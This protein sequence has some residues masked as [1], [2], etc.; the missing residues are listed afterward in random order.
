M[1]WGLASAFQGL[2]YATVPRRAGAESV[3]WLEHIG[4]LDP[5]AA[6]KLLEQPD[7]ETPDMILRNT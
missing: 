7:P 2:G 4:E 6:R 5:G 1:L 3:E